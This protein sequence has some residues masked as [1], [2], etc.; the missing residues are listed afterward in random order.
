M[1]LQITE[2]VICPEVVVTLLK[3]FPEH[4]LCLP[5]AAKGLVADCLSVVGGGIGYP[6]I[7]HTWEIDRAV[8]KVDIPAIAEIN[9]SVIESMS[10]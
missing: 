3:S 1:I 9:R 4:S 5:A 6:V 8:I 2:I 7:G 10:R